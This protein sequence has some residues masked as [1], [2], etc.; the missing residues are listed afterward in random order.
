MD[1][2]LIDFYAA[3]GIHADAILARTVHRFVRLNPRFDKNETLALL[4]VRNKFDKV[5]NTE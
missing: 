4:K 1:Q 2:E 3:Q 5:C